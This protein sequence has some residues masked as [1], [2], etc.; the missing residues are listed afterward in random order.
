M[1]R[2]LHQPEKFE[3]IRTWSKFIVLL[4]QQVEREC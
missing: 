3:V 4:L 2:D 1:D